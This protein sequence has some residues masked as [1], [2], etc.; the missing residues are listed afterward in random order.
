MTIDREPGGSTMIRI[1]I[2]TK[3]QLESL[4]VVPREAIGDVVK[5]LILDNRRLLAENNAYRKQIPEPM[6]TQYSGGSQ[7]PCLM[8]S[9]EK[10]I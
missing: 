10:P 6:P 8:P 3:D 1:A 5:R 2:E 7:Q 9:T 4:K